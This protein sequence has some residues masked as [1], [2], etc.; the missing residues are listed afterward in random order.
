MAQDKK[1]PIEVSPSGIAS[2]AKWLYEKDTKFADDPE[3]AKYS[4]TVLFPKDAPMGKARLGNGEDVVEGDEWLAHLREL[5][6]QNNGDDSNCPVKDGDNQLDKRGKPKKGD[7]IAK[8]WLGHWV[9]QFKTGYPPQI[10]DTKK[11]DL[12]DNVK[13]WGGDVIKVAYRPFAYDEGISLRMNAVML[14]E[15]RA[16]TGGADAFG[17]DEEGY[18]ADKTAK[19]AFGGGD[20]NNGDF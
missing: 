12:P 15:K 4:V 16:Q 6:E 14:V 9:V 5:H 7:K 20:D 10:V 2:Y 19:D 18:V 1:L 17:D 13:V 3:K 8:A 11:N